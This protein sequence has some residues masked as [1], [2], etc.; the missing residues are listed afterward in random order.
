MTVGVALV[1]V[2]IL[3][4]P[5]G[6]AANDGASYFGDFRTTIIPYAVGYFTCAAFYWRAATE[7]SHEFPPARHIAAA[8]KMVAVLIAALVLAPHNLVGSVHVA[9]GSTLFLVEMGLSVYLIA[10]ARPF[11]ARRWQG[12]ILLAVE[13]AS[14]SAAFYYVPRHHGLLLQ[15]QTIYQVAFAVLLFTVFSRAEATAARPVSAR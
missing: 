14:G 9:I 4:R 12:I 3:I 11:P 2:C 6:W 7:L 13:F 1:A 15:M 10:K 5:V 8:V